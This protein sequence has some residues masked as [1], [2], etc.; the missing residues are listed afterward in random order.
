[1]FR[2][3]LRAAFAGLVVMI[4]WVRTYTA[5]ADE[6]PWLVVEAREDACV[7]PDNLIPM[8]NVPLGMCPSLLTVAP[9]LN[10]LAAITATYPQRPSGG[11]TPTG[12]ALQ[13]VVAWSAPWSA[14]I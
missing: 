10:N 8:R 12:E 5:R 9:A 14:A 3:V 4:G 1:V 11:F 7:D 6:G 13:A 2:F